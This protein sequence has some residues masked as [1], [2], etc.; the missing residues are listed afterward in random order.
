MS[1]IAAPVRKAGLRGMRRREAIEGYLYISPW[2][3][4]FLVFS[5]GPMLASLYLSFTNYNIIKDPSFIGIDNYIFIMT[6][7]RLFWTALERTALYAVASV[8]I[9]VGGSLLLALLL[10]QKLKGTVIYRTMFFLPSLTPIVASALLWGW[11]FQPQLGIL[12]YLLIQVGIT[13]PGWLSSIEWALPSLIIMGLWGSLGG[14]RMIIF[15]AGL[16]GVSQELY[17][18][19]AI[20]GANAWS[21]FRNVTLPMITPTIFFNLVLGIIGSFSV[22]TVAYIATNG[23]PANATYFF[24]FHIFNRGFKDTEMGYASALAWIFFAILLV[25]TLIQFQLQRRW[26]YYEEG[27]NR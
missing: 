17:E 6:K 13:G 5:F 3:I 27:A 26:V 1:T 2:L 19:A 8:I 7:D 23:G 18:A 21:R 11:I 10:D 9:G 20:D 15:L 25:F 22:F 4:G 16:Q 12:N 24:V 14:G